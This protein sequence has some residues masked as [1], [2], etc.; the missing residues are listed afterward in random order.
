MI[1]EQ[2]T[3]LRQWA[4]LL[5]DYSLHMPILLITHDLGVVAEMADQVAVMYRGRIVER[6]STDQIFEDPQHPYTRAL[7]R[8]IEGPGKPAAP[9]KK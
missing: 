2:C 5:L 7:M 3:S 8:S 9:G 6:A 4:P 1:L